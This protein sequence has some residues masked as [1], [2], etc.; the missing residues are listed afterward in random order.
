MIV[1]SETV[2][3]YAS[4]GL[5]YY[6]VKTLWTPSKKRSGL[7]YLPVLVLEVEANLRQNI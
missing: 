1:M 6:K 2:K 3:S 7:G 5:S 4:I